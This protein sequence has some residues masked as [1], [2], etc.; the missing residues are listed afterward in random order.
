MGNVISKIPVEDYYKQREKF[1]SEMEKENA[2]AEEFAES[3]SFR[4]MS[5]AKSYDDYFLDPIVGFFIPGFG[6]LLSSMASIPAL[7]IAI[8]KLRSFTL[9]IAILAGFIIDLIVGVI[10]IAGDIIDAF[11]KSNKRSYRFIIGYYEDDPEVKSEINKKA[12]IGCILLA[13]IGVILWTFYE[14]V[15]GIY[16]W[17]VGLF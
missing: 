11:Y 17:V 9:T 14:M 12:V 13:L 4:L 6:D 7:H 3:I 1:I 8:F 2:K 16:N 5:Y 15:V 10:P